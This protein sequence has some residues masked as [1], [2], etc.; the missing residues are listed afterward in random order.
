MSRQARQV[1]LDYKHPKQDNGRYI[2]LFESDDEDQPL[3][4]RIP[5]PSPD[6]E[7]GWC[8]YETV[9]EGTPMSPVFRTESELAHWLTDN[10]VPAFADQTASYEKWFQAIKRKDSPTAV[11]VTGRPLAAGV[12]D[13]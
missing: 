8:M 12:N 5:K 3:E 1:P 2:P 7:L 13:P 4:A 10:G 9:S 11:I 6:T